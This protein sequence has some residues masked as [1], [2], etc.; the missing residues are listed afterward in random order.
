MGARVHTSISAAT[1]PLLL[2]WLCCLIRAVPPSAA[3]PS[4]HK[5][6]KLGEPGGHHVEKTLARHRIENI[7]GVKNKSYILPGCHS[8]SREVSGNPEILKA[9]L[10]QLDEQLYL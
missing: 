5:S 4:R 8:Q 1:A 6:Y 10:P 7:G 3:Q 9:I 2:L